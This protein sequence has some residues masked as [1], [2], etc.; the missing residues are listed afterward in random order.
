MQWL[1][2]YLA[3]QRPVPLWTMLA[4]HFWLTDI[5][6]EKQRHENS[7]GPSGSGRTNGE[8]EEKNRKKYSGIKSYRGTQFF[9]WKR[10]LKHRTS[11]LCMRATC[12]RLQISH[13]LNPGVTRHLTRSIMLGSSINGTQH[14]E[15]YTACHTALGC[16][17][18]GTKPERQTQRGSD[19]K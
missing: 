16:S 12:P 6:L 13:G 14:V 10:C 18:V 19:R 5:G 3:I 17:A 9:R 15:S 11:A 4:L 2:T 8:I 1:R 7:H